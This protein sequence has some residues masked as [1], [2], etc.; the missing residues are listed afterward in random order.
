MSSLT[1]IRVPRPLYD[2]LAQRARASNTTLAVALEH[3][4]DAADEQDF[5]AA[6]RV[7]NRHADADTLASVALRDNLDE[8]ADD[9]HGTARW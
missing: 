8:P 9:A 6:V 2:R 4:L 1:T 3:A 7:S 5:W